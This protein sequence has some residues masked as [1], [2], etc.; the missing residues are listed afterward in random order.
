MLL[1]P[2]LDVLKP[3]L[4]SVG[5]LLR[6]LLA[7]VLGLELGRTDVHVQSIQCTPAQLVY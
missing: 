4:N 3:L 6:S 1:K 5:S 7:Q 2:A